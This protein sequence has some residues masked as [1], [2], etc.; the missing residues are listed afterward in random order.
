[1]LAKHAFDIRLIIDD[2][3]MGAQ[4]MPPV[5]SR[6]DIIRGSMIMNSVK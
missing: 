1:M 3:N 2:E 4:V 5:L 6:A